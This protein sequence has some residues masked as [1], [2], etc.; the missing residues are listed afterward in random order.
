MYKLLTS[1]L[2]ILPTSLVAQTTQERGL[3]IAMEADKRDTGW[4][5]STANMQMILTNATP[6]KSSIKFGTG[7]ILHYSSTLTLAYS[8]S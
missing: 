3:E 7:K 2:L 4:L 5:D 1:L 8:V 6:P